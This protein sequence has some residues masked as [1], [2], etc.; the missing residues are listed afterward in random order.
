MPGEL[1]EMKGIRMEALEA[2]HLLFFAIVVIF[3]TL[4]NGL[5]ALLL[6]KKGM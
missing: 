3:S 2:K 5:H 1:A 4:P 6:G